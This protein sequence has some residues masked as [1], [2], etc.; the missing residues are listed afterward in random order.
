MVSVETA[1]LDLPYDFD[2][3]QQGDHNPAA[4]IVLDDSRHGG[5]AGQPLRIHA[6]ESCGQCTCAARAR[7]GWRRALHRLNH[8]EGRK[9]DAEYLLHIAQNIQGRTICAFGEAAPGRCS[10]S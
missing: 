10:A 5:N 7:F 3:L 1:L 6:H 4:V 2:S 8:G 9:P